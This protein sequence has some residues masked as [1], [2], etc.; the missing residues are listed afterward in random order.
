MPFSKPFDESMTRS[1]L[2]VSFLA[3]LEM[4]RLR[5]MVVLQTAPLAEIEI[6]LTLAPEHDDIL[7][8]ENEAE[9][10]SPDSEQ[11]NEH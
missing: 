8:G 2:I 10:L 11:S 6:E 1:D 3:V 9:P 4:T 7:L 5:M